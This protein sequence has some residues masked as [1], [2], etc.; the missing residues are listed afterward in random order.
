MFNG[1]NN[2][3]ILDF[4]SFCLLVDLYSVVGSS[5]STTCSSKYLDTPSVPTQPFM[6]PVM[7]LCSHFYAR[8]FYRE[9]RTFCCGDGQIRLVVAE[10]PVDLRTYYISDALIYA[11]FRKCCRAY[12]N[13]FAFTSFGVKYDKELCKIDKGIYTFRVRDK[14]YHYIQDL[15]PAERG[16]SYLQLYFYD[17]ENEIDNRIRLSDRLA[18]GLVRDLISLLSSNP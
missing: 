6:L 7:T 1:P 3:Y 4:F 9:C 10:M 2:F 11:D 13:Q 14:V 8:M 15:S 12:N 16:P 17:T 18:A 5:T